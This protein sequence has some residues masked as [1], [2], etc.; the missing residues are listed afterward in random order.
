MNGHPFFKRVLVNILLILLILTIYNCS[1]VSKQSESSEKECPADP[2]PDGYARICGNLTLASNVSRANLKDSSV[3]VVGQEENGIKADSDGYFEVMVELELSGTLVSKTGSSFETSFFNTSD[4]SDDYEADAKAEQYKN[5]QLIAISSNGKYG[6][7]VSDIELHVGSDSETE[8]ETEKSSNILSTILKSTETAPGQNMDI[9]DVKMNKT[10]TI[11][12]VVTLEFQ[13]DHTGIDVYIPGTSFM[14]K[15]DNTGAFTMTGVP[16]GTYQFLR[17]E[18]PGYKSSVK[19]NI[20]VQ[21]DE[22]TNVEGQMLPLST[23]SEGWILIN[24]G[25]ETTIFQ[26]VTLTIGYSE[27]TLLMW[28]TEDPLFFSGGWQPVQEVAEYEFAGLGIKTIYIRFADVNGLESP[29]F[30]DSI[31]IIE[32]TVEV[33]ICLY[34]NSGLSFDSGCVYR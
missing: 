20:V 28:I 23:G 27:D 6:T 25:A 34:D 19:T 4:F 26:N 7:K 5:F 13:T 16:E 31:E 9:G 24:D 29:V 33:S 11:T 18:K 17:S 21:S 32:P 22:V 2:P 10:G 15:T 1:S 3:Y 14:A 30:S 12:G 8:S